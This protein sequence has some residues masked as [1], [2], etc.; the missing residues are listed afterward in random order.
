MKNKTI[1]RFIRNN[2]EKIILLI[3][4]LLVGLLAYIVLTEVI[5]W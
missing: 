1:K 4:L 3:S 2:S 5:Y